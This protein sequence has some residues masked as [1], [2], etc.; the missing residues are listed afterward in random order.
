MA[1]SQNRQPIVGFVDKVFTLKT[2][3]LARLKCVLCANNNGKFVVDLFIAGGLVYFVVH[4]PDS[5]TI[6]AM[7]FATKYF[8]LFVFFSSFFV[9]A[10]MYAMHVQFHMHFFIYIF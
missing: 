3:L 2:I 10:V 8:H 9:V 5:T 4:Q 1:A 7:L 6:F